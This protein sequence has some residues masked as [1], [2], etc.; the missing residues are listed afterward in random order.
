LASIGNV[1]TLT[2]VIPIVQLD[3]QAEAVSAADP[4][5][6]AAPLSPLPPGRDCGLS[7]VKFS[8]P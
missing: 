2:R 8:R 7:L 5:V 3:A 6:D 1:A 4:A